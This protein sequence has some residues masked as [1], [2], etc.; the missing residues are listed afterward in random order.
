MQA[1]PF[2]RMEICAYAPSRRRK[3]SLFILAMSPSR[4]FADALEAEQ[5]ILDMPIAKV[6]QRRV[7]EVGPQDDVEIRAKL[8]SFSTV[9]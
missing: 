6:P 4:S 3:R 9:V 1:T 5:K 8:E 2:H 7:L